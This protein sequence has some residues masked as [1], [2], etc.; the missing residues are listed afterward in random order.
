MHTFF[1]YL[2]FIQV[3]Y[4]SPSFDSPGHRIPDEH[5]RCCENLKGNVRFAAAFHY[6]YA[7]NHKIVSNDSYYA[8]FGK[9]GQLR[10]F[11]RTDKEGNLEKEV[12]NE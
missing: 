2:S 9:D 11:E 12:T 8:T 6:K 4:N 7:D 5:G 3:V 10:H 1:S